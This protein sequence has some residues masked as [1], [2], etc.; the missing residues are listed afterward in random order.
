MNKLFAALFVSSLL[1]GWTTAF[2]SPTHNPSL[3]GTKIRPCEDSI[4]VPFATK[5][6]RRSRDDVVHRNDKALAIATLE[7]EY[8]KF[9]D[10]LRSDLLQLTHKRRQVVQDE[11]QFLQE[12]LDATEMERLA[13][14]LDV[15]AKDDVLK[16]AHMA[17][18][19]AKGKKQRALVET[20]FAIEHAVLLQSM[21]QDHRDLESFLL[22]EQAA[23]DLK[24]SE[25]L[26]QKSQELEQNA[27]QQESQAEELLQFLQDKE[28]HLQQVAN[29]RD[30][31]AWQ[32]WLNEE[33]T[34][35][36][37]NLLQV[38]SMEWEY[39]K[40]WRH[41]QRDLLDLKHQQTQVVDEEKMLAA[42]A[43]DLLKLQETEQVEQVRD[44][45]K[46]LQ[47]ANEALK[48]AVQYKQRAYKAALWAIDQVDEWQTHQPE[49]TD[50]VDRRALFLWIEKG[51]A[52]R[53][54]DQADENA[55]AAQQHQR[56]AIQ[57]EGMAEDVLLMLKQKER[58]L[59]KL[60]QPGNEEDLQRW[61]QHE[62]VREESVLQRVRD[63]LSF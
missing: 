36:Y 20:E 31:Q 16:E 10:Q 17:V 50:D 58:A 43:E 38:A 59:K 3:L 51:D 7:G 53:Y 2:L 34:D 18:H 45:L 15:V 56:D 5:N 8:Q 46:E 52:D 35:H 26:I 48:E 47:R 63:Q 37:Q 21:G 19:L 25:A 13:Q 57:K 44:A 29:S 6:S 33:M 4:A 42:K 32:T 62:L 24:E 14:E 41:L 11:S 30:P 9:K 39:Q 54:I 23:T 49:M 61:I 22:L 12:E 27:L 1:E 55:K 40:M 60:R 28:S